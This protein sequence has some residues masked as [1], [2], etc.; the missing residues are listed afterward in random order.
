VIPKLD[1][2]FQNSFSGTGYPFKPFLLIKYSTIENALL[3]KQFCITL[4]Q[5]SFFYEQHFG[6]HMTATKILHRI[7]SLKKIGNLP[8]FI[9]IPNSF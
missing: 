8:K 9:I 5:N 2:A 7:L 3:K 1:H 4:A 6:Q